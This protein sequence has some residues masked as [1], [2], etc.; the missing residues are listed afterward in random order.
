[1]LLAGGEPLTHPQI[2]DITRL[3]KSHKVKPV[4]ITNGVGLDRSLVRDLKKAGIFGFTFHVDV[5]Q[6]RPGWEGKSEE[7]LNELR[8]QFAEMLREEGGL[9]C[10]FNVTIFPDTL[11]DVPCIVKWAVRNIDKVNILTLIPVRMVHRDDPYDYYV[12]DKKVDIA[13]TP[14][15]SS[16]RY[17]PLTSLD[18]Y[19]EIRKVLPDY[20][21]CA[22]LGGTA[23][24]TSFKWVIGSHMGSVKRSYGC[25]GAR[26]M[27]FL[28]N[29]QHFFKGRYLAYTKPRLNRQAK[30]MFLF[31]LFDKQ[32]RKTAKRFFGS[33]FRDPAALFRGLYVQSISAVQPVDI[34]PTGENDN[35]DGCPNKT[36]WE[37]RL[38]SACR[39][40]EYMI[41]G[42]PIRTVPKGP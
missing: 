1:M 11:N 30:L 42:G 6:T 2:V 5:H 24:P 18:I 17:R 15:V 4:L 31:G 27:E 19:R 9:S 3:V 28:Q 39:L 26:T 34:L 8:Q 40:E 22:Y 13:R 14:Y 21:F 38:V 25:V 20:K 36:Y 16:E 23:L 33:L 12:G 35:C 37:D 29:S 10:A 41:Y 7:E 32:I